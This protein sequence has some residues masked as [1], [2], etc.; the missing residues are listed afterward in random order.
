MRYFS[1]EARWLVEKSAAAGY[2]IILILALFRGQGGRG[3]TWSHAFA[4]PTEQ[5][6]RCTLLV[7]EA[8]AKRVVGAKF[9]KF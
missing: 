2:I 9:K 1:P 3:V 4:C 7:E 6:E 8:K 5:R